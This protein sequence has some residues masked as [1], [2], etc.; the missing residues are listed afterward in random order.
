VYPAELQ[1]VLALHFIKR[2]I[3][4]LSAQL[5]IAENTNVYSHLYVRM[6]ED[7]DGEKLPLFTSNIAVLKRHKVKFL[8]S[9]PQNLQY[10]MLHVM[11]LMADQMRDGNPFE[12][13]DEW[14]RPI[15]DVED[16]FPTEWFKDHMKGIMIKA[17]TLTSLDRTPF[18]V[19]AMLQQSDIG[20]HYRIYVV[21]P[22]LYLR[23]WTIAL[24]SYVQP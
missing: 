5:G 9:L 1:N 10:M 4:K 23:M 16:P 11:P 15:G 7:G 21:S 22:V 18:G 17:Q 20:V 24:I 12:V 19:F 8:Q 6:I 13:Y 14:N 3:Q 2:D